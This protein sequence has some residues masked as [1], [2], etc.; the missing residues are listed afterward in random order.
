MFDAVVS[1]DEEIKKAPEENK[2][3]VGNEDEKK[4][5]IKIISATNTPIEEDEEADY[6]ELMEELEK[7]L[8]HQA[9]SGN[10][11]ENSEDFL[12]GS[13]WG[14]QPGNSNSYLV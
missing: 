10:T 7:A 6:K 14:L 3:G 8:E 9:A 11:F 5:S 4:V 2:L 12:P 13:S 1:A